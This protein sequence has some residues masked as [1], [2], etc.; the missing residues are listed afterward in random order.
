[1]EEKQY[2]EG[3]MKKLFQEASG[4]FRRGR[5][6]RRKGRGRKRARRR[7]DIRGGNQGGGKKNENK[8]GS[9]SGWNTDGGMEVC[10]GEI[11]E[12]MVELM[13]SIWKEG[14]IPQDQRN[15]IIVPLHKRGDKEKIEN[16][17]SIS[18]LCTAYKIYAE[19]LRKRL[20]KE[21]E[22]KEMLPESQSGFRRGRSTMDNIFILNHLIQ[23]KKKKGEKEKIYMM[24]A[25]LKAVFD[26][27]DR[28]TGRY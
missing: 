24:F 25:D 1:M 14:I 10:G 19:I 21:V 3:R 15:G 2:K 8:R 11:M 12:K 16:Y 17:R 6:I 27:V 22:I 5:D 26:K 28:D 18:L 20:E 7:G 9:W 4:Q 23:K 13:K